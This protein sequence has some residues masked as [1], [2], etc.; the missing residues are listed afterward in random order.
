VGCAHARS[1]PLTPSQLTLP[2]PPFADRERGERGRGV[3]PSDSPIKV[4]YITPAGDAELTVIVREA[5]SIKPTFLQVA[6]LAQW[7]DL[8]TVAGLLLPRGVRVL[9]SA[10]QVVTQ[11]AR[12]TGTLVG[13]VPTPPRTVYRYE[14]EGRDG[15]RVTLA[16]VARAGR[17]FLVAGSARAATWPA[18]AAALRAAVSSFRLAPPALPAR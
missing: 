17:I 13:V 16:A 5:A 7:G 1:R 18:Q 4:R 3:T 12:D 8:A 11:P 15:V 9:A 10:A 6:D 2:F 14:F